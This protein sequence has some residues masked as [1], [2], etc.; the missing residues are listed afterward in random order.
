MGDGALTVLIRFY[1]PNYSVTLI[2]RD[3]YLHLLTENWYQ[4]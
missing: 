2:N 4:K 1:K 3:I